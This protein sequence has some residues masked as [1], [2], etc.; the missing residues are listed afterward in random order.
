MRRDFTFRGCVV[1]FPLPQKNRYFPLPDYDISNR[2]LEVKITGKILDIKY[3]RK[4]AQILDLLLSEI[5][6]LD[7]VAKRKELKN[8]EVKQLK[9]KN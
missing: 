8:T 6:L 5:V 4:L 3:A 7:K 9:Q 2:K 1:W